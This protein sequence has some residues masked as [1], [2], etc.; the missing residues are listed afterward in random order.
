MSELK[1]ILIVLNSING[2]LEI[3]Q[4]NCNHVLDNLLLNQYK[5]GKTHLRY[6]QVD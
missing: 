5:S 3:S 4:K 1:H 2:G 6:I